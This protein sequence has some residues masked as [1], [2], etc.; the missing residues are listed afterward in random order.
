MTCEIL[1]LTTNLSLLAEY[2]WQGAWRCMKVIE[3]GQDNKL[4]MKFSATG[5]GEM[6][7]DWYELNAVA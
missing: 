3:L 7:T 4:S 6:E 5:Q 2:R 1:Q